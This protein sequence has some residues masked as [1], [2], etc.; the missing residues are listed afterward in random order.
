MHKSEKSKKVEGQ[1]TVQERGM[2]LENLLWWPQLDPP[3]QILKMQKN[4]F[5]V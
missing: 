1:F 4:H 5:S 3:V 2:A